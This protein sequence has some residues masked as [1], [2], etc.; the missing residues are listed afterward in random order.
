MADLAPEI[1]KRFF[2]LNGNPLSGGK[3]YTYEAGTLLPKVTYTDSSESS[4]NAN[5]IV[6]DS[7][8]YCDVWIKSG[9]FKFVLKDANDVEIWTRDNIG[10]NWD[11]NALSFDYVSDINNFNIVTSVAS[12]AL[13]I[14]VKTRLGTDPTGLSPITIGMRGLTLNSGYSAKRSIFSATSLTIPSGATLGHTSGNSHKIFLYAIFGNGA[15]E[16]AVSQCL[17]KETGL[18]ST[19]A[20]SGSATS[21][22]VMYSQVA[23]T[24][25]PCRLV[26]V[27]TSIQTTAGLWASNIQDIRLGNWG[28]LKDEFLFHTKYAASS[29]SINTSSSIVGWPIK[30]KDTMGAMNTNVVTVPAT[31]L[32]QCVV[33][34]GAAFSAWA[35]NSTYSA[36]V[37]INGTQGPNIDQKNIVAAVST[38]LLLTGTLD[39]DLNAGDTV[40]IQQVSS[41]PGHSLLADTNYNIWSLRLISLS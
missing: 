40:Q 22:R 14:A 13:T 8:G 12:N 1:R 7:N 39:L 3:L 28:T 32:Y 23:R 26:A 10:N 27:L 25:V 11:S 29:G 19:T 38:S 15:V 33:H 41:D 24:N 5:P 20:I 37:F 30:V 18:V 4:A 34:L 35:A 2:D 21:N 6:L 36:T 31:G 9:F 17:F 16:L